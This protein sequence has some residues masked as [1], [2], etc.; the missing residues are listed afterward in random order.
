MWFIYN[1]KTRK[2]KPVERKQ[3]VLKKETKKIQKK[4]PVKKSANNK[5]VKFKKIKVDD[6]RKKNI[7]KFKHI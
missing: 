1:Q 7:R 2:K 4:I 5:I 6:S 3:K